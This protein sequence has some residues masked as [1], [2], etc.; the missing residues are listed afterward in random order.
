MTWF[1]RD[2]TDDLSR[3]EILRRLFD[4]PVIRPEKPQA[5]CQPYRNLI[6]VRSSRS[7]LACEGE[8]CQRVAA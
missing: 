6:L 5:P 1:R 3:V 4:L 7:V 2:P 8:T